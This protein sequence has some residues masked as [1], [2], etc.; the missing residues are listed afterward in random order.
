MV[1]PLMGISITTNMAYQATLHA[2]KATFLAMLRQG[3]AFLP[4]IL[5][6]PLII[7]LD[8]VILAQSI[9]DVVTFAISIVFFI[10]FLRELNSLKRGV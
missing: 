5:L 4:C 6:L 8:G 3:I 9:A 1:L 10:L 2:G 7:G